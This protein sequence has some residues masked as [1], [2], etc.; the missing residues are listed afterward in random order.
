MKNFEE[1]K[2]K[3]FRRSEERINERKKKRNRII[4]ICIPLLICL[5]AYSIFILP[6]MMPAE[7][8]DDNVHQELADSIIYPVTVEFFDS[9]GNLESVYT[10]AEETDRICT[11]LNSIINENDYQEESSNESFSVSGTDNY[12][13]SITDN[14]GSLTTYTVSGN[15][16]FNTK[17]NESHHITDQQKDTLDLF[18]RER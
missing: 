3:I 6:A 13:I 8:A 14:I 17:T 5:G 2:A 18:R 9:N 15:T 12:S 11:V 4:L 1:R 10:K 7:S 16:L